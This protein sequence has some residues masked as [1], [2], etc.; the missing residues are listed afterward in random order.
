MSLC[1]FIC[2]WF[3]YLFIYFSKRNQA[4]EGCSERPIGHLM[5]ND[6]QSYFSF[7][8]DSFVDMIKNK[9]WAH[10]CRH[11]YALTCLKDLINSHSVSTR[12]ILR[13]NDNNWLLQTVT[14]LNFAR[15]QSMFLYASCKVW[16]RTNEKIVIGKGLTKK[17][18]RQVIGNWVILNSPPIPKFI[19][20]CWWNLYL[21]F[22]R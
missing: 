20:V 14:R 3:I 18:L 5:S 17:F 10:K 8:G 13:V 1:A 11:G 7:D 6:M 15:S 21:A 19:Y 16:E 2:G 4:Q 9:I 12:Y 22:F